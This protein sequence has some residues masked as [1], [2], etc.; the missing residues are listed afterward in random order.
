MIRADFSIEL[1]NYLFC[2]IMNSRTLYEDNLYKI[3]KSLSSEKQSL[4]NL[5]IENSLLN[6][7]QKTIQS[8]KFA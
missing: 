3:K 1:K 8:D 6:F 7:E 2:D 4:D 5:F